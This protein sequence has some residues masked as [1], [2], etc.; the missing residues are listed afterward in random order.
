MTAIEFEFEGSPIC[1]DC[2]DCSAIWMVSG[3]TEMQAPTRPF[4]EYQIVS[5]QAKEFGEGQNEIDFYEEA[6]GTSGA[7]SGRG[8]YPY[9]KTYD[10]DGT[11]YTMLSDNNGYYMTSFAVQFPW[12]ANKGMTD[13]PYYKDTV[14]PG[15]AAADKHWWAQ[16]DWSGFQSSWGVDASDRG[17]GSGAGDG[18]GANSINYVVMKFGGTPT[19]KVWSAA[20]MA[21]FMGVDS[22]KAEIEEDLEW[23]YD[24][25]V[26]YTKVNMIHNL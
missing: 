9:V 8:N 3:D 20:N 18:P 26:T 4:N 16:Q 22:M 13:N 14:F 21:G 17:W 1:S 10:A 23:L 12:F 25:D 7:P 2:A 15:Q 24:N 11:T 6:F 5:Y 19:V